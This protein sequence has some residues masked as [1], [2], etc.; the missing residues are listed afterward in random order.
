MRFERL[1]E[2]LVADAVV[3]P[4]D[5][6]FL[7]SIHEPT[8]CQHAGESSTNEQARLRK[9][10]ARPGEPPAVVVRCGVHVAEKSDP[11]S[12]DSAE[13]TLRLVV[14]YVLHSASPEDLEVIQAAIERRTG[15]GPT[16]TDTSRPRSMSDIVQSVSQSVAQQL[17]VDFDVHDMARRVVSQL[18]RQNEPSIGD[19]DLDALLEVW[20]P[21]TAEQR[22]ERSPGAEAQL[23]K[24]VV[25]SMIRQFVSYSLGTMEEIEKAELPEGWID[26]YWSA[27]STETREAIAS[28]LRGDR[29]PEDFWRSVGADI[30]Q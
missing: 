24:A 21:E 7:V 2:L 23:P 27:F 22:G 6:E 17:D 29:D 3:E 12:E 25:L 28:L 26:R 8:F 18:I 19:R 15:A 14:R 16:Q 4:A 20:V 11:E 13:E 5:I 10:P 9:L 30:D 1:S